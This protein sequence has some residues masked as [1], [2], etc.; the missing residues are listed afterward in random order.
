MRCV[1]VHDLIN[2]ELDGD[3][4]VEEQ[5]Q[6]HEHISACSECLELFESLQAISTQLAALPKI[7]PPLSIVDSILPDIEEWDRQQGRTVSSMPSQAK[8]SLHSIRSKES[9][10]EGVTEQLSR[11]NS[12]KRKKK[13]WWIPGS[14][15]AAA[16]LAIV[17]VSSLGPGIFD[18]LSSSP[19][20]GEMSIMHTADIPENSVEEATLADDEYHVASDEDLAK[21]YY[22]A[23]EGVAEQ[24][25]GIA[26]HDPSIP[27]GTFENPGFPSPDG[28]FEA[29][30]GE[31]Q[32]QIEIYQSG[33]L[34]YSPT[35]RWEGPWFINAMEWVTDTS[36]YVE[37]LNA[38]SNELQYW[39][40]HAAE[41][42]EEQL[43]APYQHGSSTR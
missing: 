12:Y 24:E 9:N 7:S 8:D 17:I 38:E 19:D 10:H 34:Y 39:V 42:R 23:H 5:Q 32:D 15:V 21:R 41:Q 11:K 3:L 35:L 28:E 25:M 22:Y 33:E 16:G 30:T 20:E 14:V 36:F 26:L 29:R 18:Q 27:N 43:D 31:N 40:I 2:R 13:S 1:E 37:L 6:L 4:T